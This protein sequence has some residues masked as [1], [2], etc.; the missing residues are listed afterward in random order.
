MQEG[1][2]DDN[3][4]VLISTTEQ[5]KSV[6]S[7]FNIAI[8]VIRLGWVNLCQYYPFLSYWFLETHKIVVN[9]H[10]QQMTVFPIQIN[11]WRQKVHQKLFFYSPTRIQVQC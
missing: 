5:L 6:R 7:T 9:F 8:S 4:D 10:N 11:S 1:Y 3:I 2:L